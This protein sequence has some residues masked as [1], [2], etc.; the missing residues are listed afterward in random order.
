MVH[1]LQAMAGA[2]IRRPSDGRYLLLQR[3]ASRDFGAG[4]W[5]YVTGRLEPGEGFEE[6]ALR[7][8]REEACLDVQI[9]FIVRTAHFFRGRETPEN[10][11]VGLIFACTTAADAVVRISDEHS[12]F[13]CV[14]LA[15]ARQM[16]PEGHRTSATIALAEDKLHL[17][18][19]GL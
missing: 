6:A 2:L 13:R 3:S 10:E 5:E 17:S 15:E 16:F 11:I 12:A 4:E 9:E 7:E 19:S 8:A 14:T 18:A 1:R